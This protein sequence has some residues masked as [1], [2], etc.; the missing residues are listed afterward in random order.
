M[1][2]ARSKLAVNVYCLIGIIVLSLGRSDFFLNVRK[3]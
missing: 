3:L 1:G 2:L